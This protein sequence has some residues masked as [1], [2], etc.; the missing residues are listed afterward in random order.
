MSGQGKAQKS[1]VS[2]PGATFGSPSVSWGV[3]LRQNLGT[4][5]VGTGLTSSL[6]LA[7]KCARH[8]IKTLIKAIASCRT[9]RLDE[10]LAIAHVVQA[11]F[12]GHLGCRHRIRQVLLVG[13][14]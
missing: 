1:Q 8:P 13:E 4:Q 7:A 9:S 2:T 3:A 14:H 10:P 11:E 6:L 5:N 12:L